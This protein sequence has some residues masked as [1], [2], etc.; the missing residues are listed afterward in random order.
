MKTTIENGKILLESNFPTG[1][2]AW[3]ARIIGIHPKWK[4]DREFLN[5]TRKGVVVSVLQ[6]NDI[7]E[8][9]RY[10]HSGK[11]SSRGYYEVQVDGN[12]LDI[13]E[14]D[15]QKKFL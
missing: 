13:S 5:S 2:K 7:I 8:L 6:P 4:F 3:V 1:N 10:S 14:A 12:L 15:V 11:N 9:V